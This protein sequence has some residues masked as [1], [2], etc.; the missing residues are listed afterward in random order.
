MR[1][2]YPPFSAS[3]AGMAAK[4]TALPLANAAVHV[5]PLAAPRESGSVLQVY[6]KA[7]TALRSSC[8][9]AAFA[10]VW[11]TMSVGSV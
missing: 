2:A 8:T 11:P 10:V 1:L 9:W 5:A 4:V 7:L 3:S 6:G